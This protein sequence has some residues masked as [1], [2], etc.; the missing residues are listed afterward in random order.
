[1]AGYVYAWQMA[2]F[3]ALGESFTAFGGVLA[4]AALVGAVAGLF[5]GKHIDAG[6]GVGAVWLTFGSLAAVMMLRAMSTDIAA[7]A[8]I[9]NALGALAVCLYM[10]TVMTSVYNQAKRSPCPLRFHV[11]TEGGWDLGCASGCVAAA[12]LSALGAPLSFAIVLSPAG[13]ALSL[14]VLWRYYAQTGSASALPAAEPLP[15]R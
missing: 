4:V 7:L 9:A 3:L 2:L 14:L 11:A 5:L 1:M 8:V 12:T 6:R 10:P 13:A 15:G